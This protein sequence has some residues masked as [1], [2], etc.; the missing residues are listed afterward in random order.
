MA[1]SAA[2]SRARLT[3]LDPI[4]QDAAD[5]QIEPQVT[6]MRLT[7]RRH[8]EEMLNDPEAGLLMRPS[9]WSG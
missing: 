6:E 9:A 4:F 3:G 8:L 2:R 7:R 1:W 5:P